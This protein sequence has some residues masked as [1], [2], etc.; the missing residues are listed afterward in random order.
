MIYKEFGKSGLKLSA[1]GFGAMRLPMLG[2]GEA[3]VVNDELAI[4]LMRRAIELGVNY[5]DTAPY[6]CNK[7]SEQAVGQAI[8]GFR[9]KVY[10]C[11]SS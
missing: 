11:F 1:L 9:D 8:E 5:F 2:E 4:P 7:L 10:I 3:S 6:Y